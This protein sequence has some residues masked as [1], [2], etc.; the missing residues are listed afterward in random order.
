MLIIIDP[1]VHTAEIECCR[2]IDTLSPLPVEIHQPA[3][4]GWTSLESID[5]DSVHGVILL[6]SGA[7][8]NDPTLEWQFHLCSWLR[9]YMALKKPLLGICYGH[10]L[11]AHLYG[12]EIHFL[13]DLDAETYPPDAKESGL[14]TV[15][16]TPQELTQIGLFSDLS[17]QSLVQYTQMDWVVSHREVVSS[18][19]QGW[20]K[21][22]MSS[23][24]HLGIEV[25]KHGDAPWWGVQAH[26]EAVDALLVHNSVELT[27]VPSPYHGYLW[28][29]A[30]LKVC[31]S[32]SF[33]SLDSLDSL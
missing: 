11:L 27:K 16:F 29:K 25:M 21:V 23:I 32:N 24:S 12:G 20:L 28:L 14:R 10:Q 3:L 22:G 15:W 33:D 4:Q 9:T 6:G 31:Q 8:P 2:L 18:L 1:G 19:P 13:S 17:S 5:L 30:F 7:S 26:I